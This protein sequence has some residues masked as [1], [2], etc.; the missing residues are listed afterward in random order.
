MTDYDEIARSMPAVIADLNY[1]LD[2]IDSPLGAEMEIRKTGDRTPQITYQPYYS[3]VVHDESQNINS[4]AGVKKFFHI[5]G[6]V[7]ELAMMLEDFGDDTLSTYAEMINA[8]GDYTRVG[9]QTAQELWRIAIEAGIDPDEE[10]AVIADAVAEYVRS[11]GRYSLTPDLTIPSNEDFALYFLQHAEEG[12]C[13]HFA[14]AAVLMLRALDIP[15]RFTSGYVVT[16]PQNRVGDTIVLTDTNAHAWVEVF[17]EDVGWLYLEVTPSGGFSTVPDPRPH[18][19]VVVTPRP[20]PSQTPDET[21]QPAREDF[22][23]G[24]IADR[25]PTDTGTGAGADEAATAGIPQWIYDAGI[26]VACII[27]CAAVLP[28]RRMITLRL[29]TNRFKQ[30]RRNL[31]AIC[32]WRYI[33]QLGCTPKAQGGTVEDL[34]LKA[35]FSQ[36]RL[37]EDERIMMIRYAKQ[38]ASEVYD[39]KSSAGRFWMKYI[40][41]L[42]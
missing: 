42:C 19:P 34:A 38:L 1:Q 31:A 3:N 35:R 9:R 4:T 2:L 37:T 39:E 30:K 8:A 6:S 10:R 40:L 32:I 33:E 17:Y 20:T 18:T 28:V 25:D 22:P 16:V 29:R 27:L 24:D 7:H 5:E 36:H 23:P 26:A 41:A 15:A 11:S 12:Y 14:T 13:I 21:E